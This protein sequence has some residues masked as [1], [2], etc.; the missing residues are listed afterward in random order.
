MRENIDSAAATQ[1][2]R[3]TQQHRAHHNLSKCGER[4]RMDLAVIFGFLFGPRDSL[5]SSSASPW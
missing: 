3:R 1:L 5:D 4:R 2:D